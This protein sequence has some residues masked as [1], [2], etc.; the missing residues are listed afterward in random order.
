MKKLVTAALAAAS[1]GVAAAQAVELTFEGDIVDTLAGPEIDFY[2]IDITN[3]GEYVFEVDAA[4]VGFDG[5]TLDAFLLVAI[6]DGVRDAVDILGDDDDGGP[7]TDSILTL[8][9][10]IGAYLVGV[11]SCCISGP[12]FEAGSNLSGGVFLGS[13]PV[14][15][16]RINGDFDAGEPVPVPAAAFL[17]AGPALAGLGRRVFRRKA[18]A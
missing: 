13:N 12:E 17:F 2:S 5:S 6:D 4:G 16:L 11:S 14:Y 8:D 9:L 15:R 1:L 3:A 7:A 10:G 18:S